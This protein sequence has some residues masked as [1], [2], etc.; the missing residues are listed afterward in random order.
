MFNNDD[1]IKYISDAEWISIKNSGKFRNL[2]VVQLIKFNNFSNV[3]T[4]KD[5]RDKVGIDLSTAK[6]IVDY[7]YQNYI[8]GKEII[9]DDYFGGEIFEE[10]D[11]N[12]E[13]TTYLS[14]LEIKDLGYW[15]DDTEEFLDCNVIFDNKTIIINKN[16]NSINWKIEIKSK[17]VVSTLIDTK[18]SN[19]I[20]VAEECFLDKKC[21]TYSSIINKIIKYYNNVNEIIVQEDEYICKEI[22]K[23]FHEINSTEYESITIN[24][25]E[26]LPS[27]LFLNPENYRAFE[28]ILRNKNYYCRFFLDIDT[29]TI[30]TVLEKLKEDEQFAQAIISMVEEFVKFSKVISK[31]YNL[32]ENGTFAITWKIIKVTAVKYF[33]DMWEKDYGYLFN[34]YPNQDNLDIYID[35]YCLC[36]DLSH[37]N[38]SVVHL[39]V[40]FLIKKGLIPDSNF[41]ECSALVC[42]KILEKLEELEQNSFESRL[43]QQKSVVQKM[44]TI[45]DVDLMNGAEFEQF[46]ANLFNK[47]GYDATV[48][49]HSGDQ[50]I[51]VLAEKNGTK[52]GI[53]AKCY[54][55]SVGNS[56]IQEAVAG[57]SYYRVD[58]VIVVTNNFFTPSAIELAQVN[59]VILWDRSILKEKI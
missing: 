32:D 9:S 42:N 10:I 31:K 7:I 20:R 46:V 17:G 36:Q 38:I 16:D 35:M 47:M 26:M 44:I 21:V 50:G 2:D 37:K 34:E 52:I 48:T 13:K 3:K 30:K 40:Y 29:S 56:A 25:I 19:L 14:P 24:F 23:I 58:K 5:L 1:S 4:I 55:G 59:D 57:K 49:K 54:S 33:S 45:D 15:N 22:S 8:N 43:M 11:N 27:V 28:S 6:S 39:F 53:Q 41:L 12:G 18:H 51:D